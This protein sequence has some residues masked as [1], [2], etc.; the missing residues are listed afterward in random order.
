HARGDLELT[1][2]PGGGRREVWFAKPCRM[3]EEIEIGPVRMVIGIDG[4]VSWIEDANGRVTVRKDPFSVREAMV[5]CMLA[6]YDYLDPAPGE[7]EVTGPE[8]VAELG[9]RSCWTLHLRDAETDIYLDPQTMLPAGR[10]GRQEGLTSVTRFADYRDVQGIAVAFTEETSVPQVGQTVRSQ[11]VDVRFDVSLPES[12]F[13]LP[14]EQVRDFELPAGEPFVDVPVNVH[15]GLLFLD[16]RVGEGAA[17]SLLIDS[18]AGRTVLDSA[19]AASL[20]VAM[21]ARLPGVGAGEV[22]EVYL[23]TIPPLSLGGIRVAEQSGAAIALHEWGPHL[24]GREIRGVIGFDFLSRFV[25][26]IDWRRARIRFWDPDSFRVPPQAVRADSSGY[27]PPVA[28]GIPVVVDAPLVMNVF[29]LPVRIDGQEATTFL[30]DT[31]AQVTVLGRQL[32]ERRGLWSREGGRTEAFGVGGSEQFRMVRLE[33]LEIA[34]F[35]VREPMA[36]LRLRQGGALQVLLDVVGGAGAG[37]LGGNV[38]ADFV[39]TLDYGHQQVIFERPTAAP[40]GEAP[41]KDE[42][43]AE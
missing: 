19:Y 8:P 26:R 42:S 21:E 11:W 10:R 5:S 28:A 13:A 1:G 9:G 23:I 3:R 14:L 43:G 29:T 41:R 4:G 33:S 30:L 18:G 2:I 37:I 20:G 22:S 36:A 25:S 40:A 34:G 32:A 38:L 16:A 39:V 12:L 35:R 27:A 24:G 15:D 31:G 17:V 7:I 6:R